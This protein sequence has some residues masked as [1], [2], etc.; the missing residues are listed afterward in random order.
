MKT[1]L[2]TLFT[3]RGVERAWPRDDGAVIFERRDSDRL[4]AGRIG[5]DGGVE[6]LPYA[7]DPALPELSPSLPGR[8]VV[9]RMGRRAVVVGPGKVIK[10][11]RPGRAQSIAEKTRATAQVFSRYGLRGANVI[12]SSAANVV[13]TILPGVSLRTV[14]DDARKAW[15]QFCD[16]WPNMAAHTDLAD[17]TI[18]TGRDEAA[19]LHRWFSWAQAFHALPE[20][21]RLGRA[22]AQV[23]DALQHHGDSL[24]FSHR[25]LHDGQILWDGSTLGILDVDTACAAEAAL[26]LANLRAHVELGALIS[27]NLPRPHIGSSRLSSSTP[28]QASAASHSYTPAFATAVLDMLDNAVARSAATSARFDAYLRSARLRLAF[29]HAFRPPA[30]AWLP[31]WIDRYLRDDHR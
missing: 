31:E 14:G 18:H 22:V 15:H 29:V 30:Q 9:H 12:S 3:L 21:P 1:A 28:S 11:V 20:L 2:G 7:S 10:L 24:V 6:L 13:F 23:C 26:D 19:V 4:R 16:T 25:D 5:H 17:L 27:S 8:L